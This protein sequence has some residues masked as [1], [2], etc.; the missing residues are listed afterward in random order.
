MQRFAGENTEKQ[1]RHRCKQH[2]TITQ[3]ARAQQAFFDVALA[4]FMLE[5][6]FGGV[7][8]QAARIIHFIHDFITRI[9]AGRAADAFILQTVADIDAHRTHLH[10][11]GAIDAVAKL[12]L[13]FAH[14]FLARAA[15]LAALDII[16]N[17]QSIV[18][19]HGALEAGIR[20]HIF[21]HLLAH[22]VGKQKR[23]KAVKSGGKERATARSEAENRRHKFAYRRE[24]AGKGD[25][26][27]CAHGKNQQ[28]FGGL[29]ADFG[30]IP[31]RF[32][33]LQPFVAV[34][35][36][37]MVDPQHDFGIHRLRAGIAAP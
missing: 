20:A 21:A 1:S 3:H 33:Q 2:R 32:I 36:D 8:D 23:H 25:A 22:N 11:H 18:V 31:R 29:N 9:D 7:A 15:R 37:K 14:I 12:A 17:H 6:A 16:R 13:F 26:R 28:I 30:E 19:E 24:P 27:P 35:L 34:A 5:R 10:A 4:V